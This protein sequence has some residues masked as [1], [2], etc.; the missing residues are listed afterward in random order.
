MSLDRQFLEAI[1]NNLIEDSP[2]N[3]VIETGHKLYEFL[4]TIADENG[5]DRGIGFSCYDI[6]AKIDGKEIFIQIKKSD[7]QQAKEAH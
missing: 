7:Y 6:W 3:E 2:T 5:V 4:K 1:E